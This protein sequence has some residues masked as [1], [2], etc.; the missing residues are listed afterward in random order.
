[1]IRNRED[2]IFSKTPKNHLK[3]LLKVPKYILMLCKV[4]LAIFT[5][6]NIVYQIY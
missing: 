2:K 1:M 6:T 4:L 3:K 5:S